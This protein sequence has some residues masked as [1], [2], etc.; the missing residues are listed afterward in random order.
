MAVNAGL[1]LLFASTTARQ[2]AT[3]LA[4]VDLPRR[5]DSSL[6]A[7]CVCTYKRGARHSP[8]KKKPRRTEINI[9]LLYQ[10]KKKII[11]IRHNAYLPTYLPYLATLST[12]VYHA[13]NLPYLIPSPEP[14]DPRSPTSP[15]LIQPI[16]TET[17]QPE[18]T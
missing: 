14:D 9:M 11:S 6:E 12:T 16:L 7:I 18:N 1:F 13:Y 5:Y 8:P 15:Y 17:N 4:T 2:Q 10:R 3:Y